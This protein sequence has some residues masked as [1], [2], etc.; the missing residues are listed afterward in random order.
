MNDRIKEKISLL[1]AK[2]G[3][4]LMKNNQGEV[5]YV[6]KAIKL[7]NRVKS[8]FIG[9]HNYKTTKLV[10]Q[11]DDFEII[12]T[13]N[14]KE[15][16]VLEF[17]LIKKY[18]P[19]FNIMFMD[20]KS[21]PYLK[22]TKGNA[23][24]L[25]VVRNTK[26]KKADYFGPFPDSGA[27]YQTKDLLNRLYPLRK[28]KTLPKKAC[29]YHHIHQCLAPCINKIEPEVYDQ[30]RADIKAFLQGDVKQLVSELKKEMQIASDELNFEK[31][32]EKYDLIQAIEHVTEHQKVQFKD[33][34]NRDIFSYY[35]DKGFVSIQGFFMHDGKVLDRDLM[36]T[37]IV[38]EPEDIFITF[39]MQYYDKNPSPYEVILPLDID[40][41]TLSQVLP[42]RY[43]QPVMGE[44]KKLLDMVT[45]NAKK[46]LEDQVEGILRDEKKRITAQEQLQKLLG[47][48][49]HSIEMVDNSHISG[50]F[51]CSGVVVFKDGM[52]S[53][54]D[55]RLYRLGQYVS[56]MDSMKEVLYRRYVRILMEKKSFNDL[57][58]VDGGWQ[59]IQ[60]ACEIIDSL[61]IDLK[62]VGLVKDDRHRTHHLMDR[63]G[64]IFEI[65][66]NS[67]LFYFLTQM[68][69]EVHRF[70]ITYHRKL[71]SKAMTKSILDDIEG[72]GEVR[73]KEL[74]RKFKTMKNLQAASLEELKSV[75]P[76]YV[77]ENVFELLRP[78][79]Q[80]NLDS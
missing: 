37:P 68:Q 11:I 5:I 76:D 30:M 1:P 46:S 41:D 36:I 42:L 70:A 57:L 17:N 55:Y 65:A 16:L 80:S 9:S 63:N 31:A 20:D 21:Y 48:E 33:R 34:K 13:N 35:V 73:K 71:R 50:A 62:V 25:T 22:L 64:E 8:Y 67:Y 29:L 39:L 53:K 14:E 66:P 2:P 26:D 40:V 47:Y 52:P 44:K 12:M 45:D 38:G 18:A 32:K 77:A 72:I 43:H 19:R 27:A 4:Y 54:K 7:S 6:G 15:A 49:I 61:Q 74:M 79:T 10:S 78:S 56:D 3:C 58:I 59:Q 23:P 51:N 60:A 28:C 69:D 75:L 24:M